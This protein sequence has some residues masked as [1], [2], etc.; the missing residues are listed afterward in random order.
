MAEC[1]E[2]GEFAQLLP[3][4]DPLR[5]LICT[6]IMR[7]AIQVSGGRERARE[8]ERGKRE[9][10]ERTKREQNSVCRQS[11]SS[12]P[13][14]LSLRCAHTLPPSSLRLPLPPFARAERG[15]G[16]ALRLERRDLDLC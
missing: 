8:A 7:D 16:R 2:D 15:V 14:A 1:Y 9:E 6:G 4:E 10:E 12:S 11:V 5:C 13:S 3:S